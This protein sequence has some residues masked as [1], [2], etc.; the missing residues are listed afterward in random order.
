MEIKTISAGF[1]KNTLLKNGVWNLAGYILPTLIA[2]P[3][4]GYIARVLGVEQFGLFTLSMAVVGYAS[5]FDGGISR[6]TI[7]EIAIHNENENE[8]LKIISCSTISVFMLSIAGSLLLYLFSGYSGTLLNISSYLQG[9]FNSSIKLLVIALPLMLVNQVWLAILAGE[10][11]FKLLTLQKT[12]SNTLLTGLPA[13][14]VFYGHSLY[15]AVMGLLLGRMGALIV[16]FFASKRLIIL[17]GLCFDREVLGRLFS[18]GGW[19]TV[20]NI[21]SPIMSYFDRFFLSNQIGAQFV[22]YYT[23]PSEGIARATIIPN[24]LATAL[25]PRVSSEKKTEHKK[26][27]VRLSYFIMLMCVV[28]ISLFVFIFSEKIMT[29]WMGSDFGDTSSTILRILIIGYI[30]NSLAQI[31][32]ATIQASGKARITAM[33]HLIELVPYLLLMIIAVK[34]FGITGAAIVWSS[35]MIVDFFLLFMLNNRVINNK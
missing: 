13:V 9:E 7:R 3:S 1:F 5:I 2:I 17:A 34:Y 32:F 14:L 10:E 21:V 31:P 20:S 25:F 12:I 16:S 8:K 30:F 23:A 11:K 4:L 33:L 27:I 24:A 28:P 19:I 22:A 35:R 18:I 29:V 26:S 6:A 15:F